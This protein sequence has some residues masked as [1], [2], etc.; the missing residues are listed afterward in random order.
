MTPPPWS[1]YHKS[2][3][4]IHVVDWWV[5]VGSGNSRIDYVHHSITFG[6]DSTSH[7]GQ[8]S[9][10]M[11]LCRYKVKMINHDQPALMVPLEDEEVLLQRLWPLVRP[12]SPPEGLNSPK[13]ISVY[14]RV[15]NSM[16][17]R[18]WVRDQLNWGMIGLFQEVILFSD[19]L[20]L[21][22]DFFTDKLALNESSGGQ[23]RGS[24]F[25]DSTNRRVEKMLYYTIL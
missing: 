22:N 16:L 6:P 17:A 18:S 1:N 15:C 2:S 13:K 25:C 14:L 10:F 3:W 4:D 21:L 12:L 5:Q 19:H 11:W 8:R 20:F 24:C 9:V 23:R 7:T